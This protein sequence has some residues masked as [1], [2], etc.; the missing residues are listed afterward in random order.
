MRLQMRFSVAFGAILAL[1][2]GLTTLFGVAVVELNAAREL[3][4]RTSER[5]A[6]VERL[7]A[8]IH[9]QESSLRGYLLSDRRPF[10]DD[11]E[12]APQR[13]SEQA[14]A[15]EAVGDGH[16]STINQI[17]SRWHSAGEPSSRSR[18]WRCTATAT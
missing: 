1:F 12:S 7:L 14:A 11:Y 15:L 2:V 10:L 5:L 9:E 17:A 13:L 4:R 6:L 18:S 3:G 16:R 8:T